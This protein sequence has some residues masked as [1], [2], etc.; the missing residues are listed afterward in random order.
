MNHFNYY[1]IPGMGADR[2][3]Y[4]K[5]NLEHG[6]VHYLDW[7]PPKKA[8]TF[9]EY[10]EEVAERITTQNNII[11]GSSMGG[12]MAVE[13]SKLIDPTSTILISAPTGIHEFPRILKLTKWTRI[14][15]VVTP[16][17]IK[18]LNFLANTFMGFKNEEQKKMFFEMMENLGPE[19]IRFSVK[20]LLDWKNEERPQGNLLQIVGSKDVL[21]DY[22][23]MVNPIVLDGGG[24]F[25][26]FD[27]SDEICAIINSYVASNFSK[28]V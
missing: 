13:V 23:K 2:R 20:A 25:S 26:C 5:F 21:F 7:L 10:A 15:H 8:N 9:E 14:H 11:I 17:M 6:S 3:I 19:F 1:L 27:R 22:K 24:H 18:R 12:M 4:S 16:A 28:E